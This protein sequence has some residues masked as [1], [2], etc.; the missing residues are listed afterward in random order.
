MEGA[1]GTREGFAQYYQGKEG[2]HGGQGRVLWLEQVS[3]KRFGG[4]EY[5][6]L[7]LCDRVYTVCECICGRLNNRAQRYQVIIPGTCEGPLICQE[8]LCRCD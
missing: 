5:V 8:Q 7:G 2:C 4:E 6:C 3:G 1:L